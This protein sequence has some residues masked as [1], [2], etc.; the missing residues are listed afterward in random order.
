MSSNIFAL[1]VIVGMVLFFALQKLAEYYKNKRIKPEPV[2]IGGTIVGFWKMP[3][4]MSILEPLKS[5]VIEIRFV[6]GGYT[7]H[8]NGQTSKLKEEGQYF[9]PMSSSNE[10]G[11]I[12]FRHDAMNDRLV[13]EYDTHPFY[14]TRVKNEL[15]A[16]SPMPFEEESV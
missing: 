14:Y 16:L 13:Q 8:Q 9:V 11:V 15:Q 1:G 3:A 7:V 4:E 10:N 12:R 6:N 5:N 2:P